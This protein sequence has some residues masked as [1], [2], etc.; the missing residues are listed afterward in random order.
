MK[1]VKLRCD[2]RNGAHVCLASKLML[3]LLSLGCGKNGKKS[4]IS[5]GVHFV[6][7]PS[8][9]VLPVCNVLKSSSV[10][11]SSL[12][13]S[14]VTRNIFL[15]CSYMRVFKFASVCISFIFRENEHFSICLNVFVFFLV[16][17]AVYFN[18]NGFVAILVH[19]SESLYAIGQNIWYQ[20]LLLSTCFFFL[21]NWGDFW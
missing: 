18:F 20:I 14:T 2:I 12:D 15:F 1:K 6:I 9:S 5:L 21:F 11:T 4:F 7:L 16:Q 10:I 13:L 8:R 3:I 19:F 17:T